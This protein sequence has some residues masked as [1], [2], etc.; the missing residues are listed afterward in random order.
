MA[1]AVLVEVTT[2]AAVGVVARTM[3]RDEAAAL[4]S[5]LILMGVVVKGAEVAMVV[6]VTW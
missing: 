2:G 1:I 3:L 5:L 4:F 6:K